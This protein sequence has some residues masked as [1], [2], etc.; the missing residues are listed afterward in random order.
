MFETGRIGGQPAP[1]RMQHK[2]GDRQHAHQNASQNRY[3]WIADR[4][5]DH[6]AGSLKPW[7]GYA[8]CRV[9]LCPRYASTQVTYG[10]TYRSD[11]SS[12]SRYPPISSF[13]PA[14]NR[15]PVSRPGRMYRGLRGF[16][17]VGEISSARLRQ[18]PCWCRHQTAQRV[19]LP[20]RWSGSHMLITSLPQ[21][22]HALEPMSAIVARRPSHVLPGKIA[23]SFVC[24][25]FCL[26]LRLRPSAPCLFRHRTQDRHKTLLKR[27]FA[28]LV[29]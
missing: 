9:A 2:D 3:L 5:C 15:K 17:H 1:A 14:R 16:H 18:H 4:V 22:D 20:A 12:F 19:K 23:I 26:S 28:A 7:T 29:P 25:L 11:A 10:F 8:H 13:Q 6:D 27:P 24:H 21:Q